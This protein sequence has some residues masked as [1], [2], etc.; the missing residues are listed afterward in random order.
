MYFPAVVPEDFG[1]FDLAEFCPVF[2]INSNSAVLEW[3]ELREDLS[4]H[5]RPEISLKDLYSKLQT[6]H[7]EHLKTIK[8]I[9]EIILTIPPSNVEVEQVWSCFSNILGDSHYLWHKRA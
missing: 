1:E 2:N 9:A 7:F 3:K 5:F 4:K 8:Q 6:D